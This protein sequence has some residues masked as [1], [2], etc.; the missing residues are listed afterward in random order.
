MA[1]TELKD[2]LAELDADQASSVLMDATLNDELTAAIDKVVQPVID[3]FH[4]A[5]PFISLGW[6][7]KMDMS[8]GKSFHFASSYG[9]M[10]GHR[11]RAKAIRDYRDLLEKA[12]AKSK[13]A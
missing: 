10:K 6:E 9:S 1:T 5:H 11:K 7:L 4:E 2:K 13:A 8:D 12:I 3:K